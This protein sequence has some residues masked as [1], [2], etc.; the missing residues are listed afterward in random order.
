[1]SNATIA[2]RRRREKDGKVKVSKTVKGVLED[3]SS[4]EEGEETTNDDDDNSEYDP[5]SIKTVDEL[6][7]SCLLRASAKVKGF[8]FLRNLEKGGGARIAVALAT[9]AMEVHSVGKYV[10]GIE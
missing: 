8:E 1:M 6:T 10:E 3:S 4:D 2:R 9:N 7:L 5:N